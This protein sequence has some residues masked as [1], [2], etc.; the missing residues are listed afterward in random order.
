MAEGLKKMDLLGAAYVLA[1]IDDFK[2]FVKGAIEDNPE[3]LNCDDLHHFL[4]EAVEAY[5]GLS[6]WKQQPDLF[7]IEE[8]V[9]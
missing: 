2:L 7:K 6:H 8:F 9:E 1:G 5:R 3:L 4:S